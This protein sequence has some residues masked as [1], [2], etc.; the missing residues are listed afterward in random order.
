LVRVEKSTPHFYEW[1][2]LFWAIFTLFSADLTNLPYLH[3]F[4]EKLPSFSKINFGTIKQ[5]LKSKSRFWHFL[6]KTPI[7]KNIEP[8]F[9]GRDSELAWR[10]HHRP[11]DPRRFEE[12]RLEGP[13]PILW[14]RFS[15]KFTHK[16]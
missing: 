2:L 15:R 9:L 5:Y 11:E 14:N 3:I 7:L 16:T 1:L 4:C 6:A 10:D 13:G 12:P 8:R